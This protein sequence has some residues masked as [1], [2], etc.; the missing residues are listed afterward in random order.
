M[1]DG[2]MVS[3]G[4]GR[5][6]Q[7]RKVRKGGFTQAKKQIVL[8]HLA[9]CC[10]LT[11]SAKAAGISVETVNAHRRRDPVFRQQVIEAIEAGYEALD[12]MALDHTARSGAGGAFVPGDTK[13]GP[14]TIDPVMALHLLRLRRAPIGQ[15]TGNGGPRPR[16]VS[17]KELNAAILAK[18]KLLGERI[19]KRKG[20]SRPVR[21]AQGSLR[22]K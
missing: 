17:E 5:R 4:N 18:L 22:S 21:Q 10:N 11:R 6:R 15:R 14:E 19:R 9:A 16:R 12:A 7:V 8:D 3:P 20:A 2:D 1:D 13:V